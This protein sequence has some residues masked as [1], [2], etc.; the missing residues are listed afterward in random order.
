MANPEDKNL[1]TFIV[2][3]SKQLRKHGVKKVSKAI[4]SIDYQEN[5][6]FSEEIL[7]YIFEVV[8]EEFCIEK[9]DLIDKKTRGVVTVARKILVVIAKDHLDITD[10]YLGFKLSRLRQSIHA[11]VKDV[12]RLDRENKYD[13]RFFER[14]DSLDEKVVKYIEEI[15]NENSE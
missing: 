2:V 9:Q 11:I 13:K 1:E 8:C 14:Y 3:L 15:K 10:E 4:Q 6:P 7:E 5:S 12:S